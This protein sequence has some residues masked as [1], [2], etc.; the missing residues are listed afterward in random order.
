VDSYYAYDGSLTT[1]GC[2][3]DVR[4]SV[5]ADGGQVSRAAVHRLHQ[6]IAR[7]PGYHGYPDNNRPVQPLNGRLITR[8]HAGADRR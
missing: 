1:P 7:F 6:V 8:I 2:A 5:L 4:W 3:Q